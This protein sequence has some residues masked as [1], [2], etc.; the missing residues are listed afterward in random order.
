MARAA[1]RLSPNIS[2][3]GSG[4]GKPFAV[5]G[6]PFPIWYEDQKGDASVSSGRYLSGGER[7]GFLSKRQRVYA[8]FGEKARKRGGTGL[9]PFEKQF[10]K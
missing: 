1:K 4:R 8:V 5:F 7:D 2:R 10:Y 9:T 6:D 3:L